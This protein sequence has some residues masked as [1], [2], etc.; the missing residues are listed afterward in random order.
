M[1]WTHSCV[2]LWFVTE[3]GDCTST[4]SR[5]W[6]VPSSLSVNCSHPWSPFHPRDLREV[7]FL[8]MQVGEI[9]NPSEAKPSQRQ[10]KNSPPLPAVHQEIRSDIRKSGSRHLLG[11][12]YTGVTPTG[13][14]SPYPRFSLTR[15]LLSL[16]LF[17]PVEQITFFFPSASPRSPS[18]AKLKYTS[19]L[20]SH[21][22]IFSGTHLSPTTAAW[23]TLNMTVHKMKQS[24]HM[25]HV[26]PE[27]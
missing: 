12:G 1:C 9:A 15:K 27:V 2:A 24:T 16:L 8:C 23:R 11:L 7:S 6:W 3:A 18:L 26:R 14:L 4:K 13:C 19:S 10:L 20:E 25:Q 22:D 17:Y 21:R 5:A